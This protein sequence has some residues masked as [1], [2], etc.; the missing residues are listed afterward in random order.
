MRTTRKEEK[1]TTTDMLRIETKRNHIKHP[2]KTT[3]GR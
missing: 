1:K 3:Q 2:Q